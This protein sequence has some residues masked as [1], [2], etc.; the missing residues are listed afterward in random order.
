M[1]GKAL[2]EVAQDPAASFAEAKAATARARREVGPDPSGEPEVFHPDAA[3]SSGNA[4]ERRLREEEL[5]RLKSKKLVSKTRGKPMG[6]EDPEMLAAISVAE[7][8]QNVGDVISALAVPRKERSRSPQ[9]RKKKKNKSK[10]D[11]QDEEMRPGSPKR[12]SEEQEPYVGKRKQRRREAQTLVEIGDATEPIPKAKAKAKAKA[13]I[14][15]GTKK[16]TTQS[17]KYWKSKNI[18]YIV[19]QLASYGDRIDPSLLTG[20]R[21]IFDVAKNKMVDEKVVKLKKDELLDMI[22][23]RVGLPQDKKQDE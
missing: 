13:N 5:L 9:D 4:N 19:D 10:V 3:S 23:A 14:E 22:Y 21:K 18:A 17:K 16:D 20:R 12:G 6:I 15:H 11:V 8:Y 1:A 7:R 2:G